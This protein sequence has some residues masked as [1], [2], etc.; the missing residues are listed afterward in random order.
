M[1]RALHQV[2]YD[3]FAVSDFWL[4][5]RPSPTLAVTL[6]RIRRAQALWF[7]AC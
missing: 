6:R 2:D 4:A 3:P 1:I 7:W 5:M